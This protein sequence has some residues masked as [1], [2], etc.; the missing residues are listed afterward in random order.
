MWP[1]SLSSPPSR[2]YEARRV[3]SCG[4]S[5]LPTNR[6]LQRN[7]YCLNFIRASS[8]FMAL[9]LCFAGSGLAQ[10]PGTQ[11]P[12]TQMPAA[13]SL[14]QSNG[15]NSNPATVAAPQP[16]ALSSAGLGD[17]PIQA[18]DTVDVQVFDAPELSVRALVS[19]TGDIPIPLLKVFH[20]AGM[21]ALEAGT[22]LAHEFMLHDF[23]R[24]PSILVTVQQ[25]ANGITVLGEVRTPGCLS[26][27]RKTSPD[28]HPCPRWRSQ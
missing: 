8:L 26:R 28:R 3:S 18:G 12:G 1:R 13:T 17:G 23:L 27:H 7:G 4:L 21:T 19:Q 10:A 11:A 20:I 9:A 5:M 25:S 6:H 2:R 14:P 22:A 15:N 24:N 16:S